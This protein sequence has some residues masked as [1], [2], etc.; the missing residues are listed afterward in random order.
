MIA[1]RLIL[2]RSIF[3][4]AVA[5]VLAV[6]IGAASA[7]AAPELPSPWWGVTSGSRPSELPSEGTGQIVLTAQ[8]L[9]DANADGAASPIKIVDV[10]PEGLAATGIE[11]IAGGQSY[12]GALFNHGPVSC[13][14]KKLTCTFSGTLPA[15]EQIEI[16]IA[17]R[18]LTGASS[19]EQNTV[20]VYGGGAAGVKTLSRPI[21]V[22]GA[23]RFGIEEYR[24]IPENAGGSIDTQAGSHPF[25]VSSV[26]TLDQTFFKEGVL[27][28]L[29]GAVA[30]PKELVGE[31]P[32]G[33]VGN[34]TAIAQCTQTQFDTNINDATGFPNECPQQSAVGVTTVTFVNSLT[35]L[36]TTTQ[37]VFNMEPLAGE[38]ARFAFEAG[39]IVPVYLEAS[40][41]TGGDYG[42][43]L[44]GSNIVQLDS[45]MSFK[46]TFWGVPGDLRHNDQRG[47]QCLR[48]GELLAGEGRCEAL[49]E[50]NPPAFL[51]MPTSCERPFESTALGGSWAAGGIASEQ[52]EPVT[53][54]LPVGLDGCNHLPFSPRISVAPDVPDAST[55]TGLTVDVHVPQESAL[56][57][58]GLAES[59]VKDITVALPEGMAVNPSGGDGLGACSESQ[60]G[61]LPGE[62]SP[63][64]DL[65]FTSGLPEPF[66]PNAS[67]IGAVTIRTPLLPNPVK[68]FVYLASQNENPFGSLVAVYLVAEDPVSGTLIKL[69]GDVHLSEAGQLVATF[70]NS[71]ELPFEDAELHFFG[72]ER[73]PLA[74]PAHCGAYTTTSSLAPWSGS[75]PSTPSATFDI[76]SGPYGSACPGSSLP[77]GPSLTGGT[78]DNNGGAFSALFDNDRPRRWPAEH[79]ERAAAYA[80]RP[81]RG[82]SPG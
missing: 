46:L 63:P 53:Y 45:L 77:F 13:S 10:L 58:E 76:T 51:M 27:K 40:I 43:T 4:V 54:R 35:G 22:G 56:Y 47:L 1:Q 60:I 23:P 57:P 7:H 39:G 34:P 44:T 50:N 74:T 71:P 64:G 37:P 24:V 49:T 8:D 19:G 75:V 80:T 62:S 81:S 36:E 9:G 28:G 29:P 38:P 15:Y 17:V 5:G 66:C 18:V 31:L 61:Y 72:G 16:R 33:L 26:L 32:T 3:S 70:E 30:L 78:I 2:G 59:S 69:A 82:Y 6:L 14:L 11:G 48:G 65:R 55:S 41:R 25:Q 42:V 21:K 20:S 52:A 73:A 12:S 79:A 67:K 68:G